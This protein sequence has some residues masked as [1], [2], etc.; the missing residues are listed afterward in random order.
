[1]GAEHDEAAA[2][3]EEMKAEVERLEREKAAR[4]AAEREGK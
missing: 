1:M 3:L 4:E 2:N